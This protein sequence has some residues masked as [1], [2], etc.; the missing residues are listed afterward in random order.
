MD[1]SEDGNAA[2]ELIS[3]HGHTESKSTCEKFLLIQPI[4]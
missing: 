3:A 2:P 1:F 4:G